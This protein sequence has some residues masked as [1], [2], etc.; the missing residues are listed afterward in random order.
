MNQGNPTVLYNMFELALALGQPL[1]TIED[2]RIEEFD[3]WQK[4]FQI[5]N[6]RK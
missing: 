4:F 1:S 3:H 2:M 6:E 5:R